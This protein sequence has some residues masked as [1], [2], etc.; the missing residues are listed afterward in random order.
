MARPARSPFEQTAGCP[1]PAAGQLDERS[2]SEYPRP[3]RGDQP[4]GQEGVIDKRV[5]VQK[6]HV[7]RTA[8]ARPP[9]RGVV[10]ATDPDV[11]RQGQCLDRLTEF[12]GQ[13]FRL[14]LGRSVVHDQD[15]MGRTG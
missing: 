4:L 13:P 11:A 8:V 9:D 1:H 6:Q 12:A 10:P 3:A 2:H 15:T 7:S 5:V 14:A